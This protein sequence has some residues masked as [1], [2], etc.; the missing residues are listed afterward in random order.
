MT[1]DLMCL[2]R[3]SPKTPSTLLTSNY[4]SGLVEPV[5]SGRWGAGNR[6]LNV[7]SVPKDRRYASMIQ[8][9]FGPNGP[10]SK[11]NDRRLATP[12]RPKKSSAICRIC[13]RLVVPRVPSLKRLAASIQ[14]TYPWSNTEMT[15]IILPEQTRKLNQ[16]R[17]FPLDPEGHKYGHRGGRKRV[18]AKHQ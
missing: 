15:V 14:I 3:V 16:D 12:A 13:R 7:H 17:P 9:T 5:E 18:G 4:R 6:C 11:R 1:Y 8:T 10:G 2:A